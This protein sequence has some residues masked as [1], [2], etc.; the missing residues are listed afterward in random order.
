MFARGS[1]A[2][3]GRSRDARAEPAN[4]RKT[5]SRACRRSQDARVWLAG[6]GKVQGVVREPCDA[7]GPCAHREHDPGPGRFWLP[8]A[9]ALP[10]VRTRPDRDPLRRR[11]HRP[12]SRRPPPRVR[13]RSPTRRPLRRTAY[14][15]ARVS[16]LH[17]LERSCDVGR[18][19]SIRRHGAE[20]SCARGRARRARSGEPDISGSGLDVA[21]VAVARWPRRAPRAGARSGRPVTRGLAAIDRVDGSAVHAAAAGPAHSDARA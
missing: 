19:M 9:G 15:Y 3:C 10:E 2:A 20:A 21:K 6:V 16:R 17:R 12:T 8:V 1:G 13:A 4:V 14:A 11:R 7:D 18:V 5:L